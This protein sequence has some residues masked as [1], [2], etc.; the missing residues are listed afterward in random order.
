MSS[1]SY[2]VVDYETRSKIDLKKVGAV[3]YA[4][5]PSTEILCASWHHG[6]EEEL[7]EDVDFVE[8]EYWCPF[9]DLRSSS[10]HLLVHYLQRPDVVIVAQ[11]A[12]FEQM[13]TK[14]VLSRKVAGISSIPVERWMCTATMAA[15]LALPRNLEGIAQVLKLP[16]QKDMPGRRHMM[17]MSKPRKPSKHN[18]AEWVA[19][20]TDFEKLLTYNLDDTRAE[21]H[22]FLNMPKLSKSER[23]IW[24]LDQQI[25]F[26]GF[27]VD[28]KLVGS[29]LTMIAEEETNLVREAKKICGFKPT[30]RAKVLDWLE[31]NGTFL[32]N[33]KAKTVKDAIENGWVEGQ[34]KRLLEIRQSISKTSTKKY[35]AFELRSRTDGRL[36]DNL[37]YH[38]ASTGRWTGL[39]V[40]PQNFP[41]GAIED[42]VQLAEIVLEKDLE[43]VRLLYGDPITAL[44]SCL[45]PVITAS[46]G[47]LLFCGDYNAI[48]ARVLFWLAKHTKGIQ[49]FAENRP[50]Y[51]EMAMVIFNLR[52]LAD[53]T[54]DQRQTG[55]RA[56][57]GCG[58]GMGHEKF[59]ASG[60]E[61]G[62][63]DVGK[64]VAY[65]AVRSY[66]ALHYPVP[67]LWSK[68]E[69]AAIRATQN[70]G[71]KF[72]INYTTWWVEDGFLW[73]KLPSGRN[74]AYRKP[75]I[76]FTM[77]P[78]DEKRATLYHEG[79]NP[80]TR[81]WECA[82]TYGGRLVENVTQATARDVMAEA[83]KRLDSKGFEIL[84]TVHDEILSEKTEGRLKEFENL[85]ALVP[86]WAKGCPIK[87]EGW[88]G[89]RYHK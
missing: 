57:L 72:S 81:K 68:Y 29:A 39:G 73:C 76:K 56:I 11:N 63:V 54:K 62:G 89:F 34:E 55:K 35:K 69:R 42:S 75:Q 16:V 6:T 71:T 78:W 13:I 22:A 4:R 37:L 25:N 27:T 58:F 21:V 2:L 85:M 8:P 64:D 43:L 36:R 48:E 60:I 23:E 66:R 24:L 40:Q 47:K 74:L 51:E 18:P 12:F 50:L 52:R 44:S 1:T 17:R 80:R 15:A 82:G 7:R 38:G 28:R 31:E 84:L 79:Q 77:T 19:T 33:L 10:L 83:I 86:S 49:G 70:P 67:E 87:V 14:Y 30:Q 88:K 46:R 61:Y 26:R 9:H 45:R 41:K 59:R 20:K 3:E 65:K 32:P 5:H 53:V